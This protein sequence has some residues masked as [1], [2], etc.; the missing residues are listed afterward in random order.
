[1][2]VEKKSLG[3]GRALVAVYAVFAVSATARATYQLVREF[4]Q[5]PVAYSLS[6][7]A[8]L[9]YLL[10]T[11]TLARP[12]LHA[13]AWWSI[14]FELIGVTSVGVLSF[15]QP[16]LFAHPSVWSKFGQGY[17]FIPLALP[18]LGIIWLTKVGKK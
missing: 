2:T 3:V 7:V 17:G 9:V 8:A 6:A 15:V 13:L 12:T 5:A 11:V 4:D 14:S 10:A 1:M 18:V 16:D